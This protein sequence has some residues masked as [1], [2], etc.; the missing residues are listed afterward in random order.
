MIATSPPPLVETEGLT[1]IARTYRLLSRSLDYYL[2]STAGPEPG[3]SNIYRIRSQGQVE[4]NETIRIIRGRRLKVA[5]RRA[6]R[7]GRGHT[8]LN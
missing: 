7:L 1:E 6:L 2:A 5:L 8:R 4:Q 3:I